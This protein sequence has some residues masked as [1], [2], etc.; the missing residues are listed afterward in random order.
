MIYVVI[1]LVIVGVLVFI[2]MSAGIKDG[3]A[4]D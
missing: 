1:I 4:K 3:K 2:P